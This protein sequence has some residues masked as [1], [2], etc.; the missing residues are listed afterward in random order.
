M[1]KLKTFIY[2]LVA[3]YLLGSAGFVLAEQPVD[4]QA[5]MKSMQC[6]SKCVDQMDECMVKS[7][8]SCAGASD[9]SECMEPCNDAYTQ[10]LGEC[11]KLNGSK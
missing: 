2:V 10:C 7:K 6:S 5:L 3:C 8:K 9:K 4:M 11:S 1:K